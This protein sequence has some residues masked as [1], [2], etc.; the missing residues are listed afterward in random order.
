VLAAGRPVLVAADETSEAADLVREAGAGIV[1]PP[2]RSDAVAA[3]IR[4]ARD[5]E[6]DL[7]QMGRRGRDYVVSRHGRNAAIAAYRDLLEEVLGA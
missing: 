5:G 3:A 7:D 1:V 2:G 6:Y 4:S